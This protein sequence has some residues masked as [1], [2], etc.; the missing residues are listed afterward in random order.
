MSKMRNIGG[1][2]TGIRTARGI[3]Q[4]K[5]GY[6]SGALASRECQRLQ[7][8]NPDDHYSSYRCNECLD[9][10]VGHSPGQKGRTKPRVD[11]EPERKGEYD[12]LVI[13]QHHIQGVLSELNEGKPPGWQGRRRKLVGDLEATVQRIL[14]IK[15][16][17]RGIRGERVEWTDEQRAEWHRQNPE[18]WTKEQRQRH[19]D[20]VNGSVK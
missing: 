14:E 1:A 7:Q 9:W 16:E 12:A 13:Q 11:A 4:G 20:F 15:A 2:D 10:H 8:E 5:I 19:R 3:C 18:Q 17:R 6:R